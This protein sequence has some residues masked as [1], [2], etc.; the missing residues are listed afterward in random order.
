MIRLTIIIIAFFF[1]SCDN[2]T[3]KLFIYGAMTEELNKESEILQNQIAER[4]QDSL[5]QNS[6][7]VIEADGITTNYLEYL[8]SAYQ[9]MWT[10]VHLEEQRDYREGKV[11]SKSTISNKF[12]FEGDSLSLKGQEYQQMQSEYRDKI[13][14]LTDSEFLK[15][16]IL[17]FLPDYTPVARDGKTI[18]PINYFF[19]DL[20]LVAVLAQIAY[21][22]K[23]VLIYELEIINEQS[24]A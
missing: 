11:L 20:P 21:L 1:M 6:Q 7:I 18:N 23:Q 2:A 14:A 4:L 12:F 19:Q 9:E 24:C 10:Q 16:R 3:D 15:E 5:I 17:R 22:K 13:S 8:E